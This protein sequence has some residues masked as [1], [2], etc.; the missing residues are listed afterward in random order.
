MRAM[1]KKKPRR[2][3]KPARPARQARSAKTAKKPVKISS[4]FQGLPV[5]QI[6]A[7]ISGYLS[8]FGFDPVLTG[9]AAAAAHIGAKVRAKS[10]DFV[11]A[12][13]EVPELAEAMRSIGFSRTGLYTYESRR[14]P[15]DV[16]FSP[17]PLAVGDDLVKE[18]TEIK[19][20]GNPMKLLNPTDACRQRL[21]M[22]YRW[23]DKE[24]FEDAV[25][26]ALKHKIDMDLVRK[27][28][29]WEWCMDRYME[30]EKKLKAERSKL[31]GKTK[32]N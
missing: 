31:K 30:F 28:S 4:N 17:P 29:D 15:V 5:K 32:N 22:Y 25:E 23:G 10:I 12:E 24:A 11:L 21:S 2:Q 9:R 16:I 27:W 26:L 7:Q 18:I 6:A 1:P 20:K 8:Q 3:A 19:V 13:H 14:C